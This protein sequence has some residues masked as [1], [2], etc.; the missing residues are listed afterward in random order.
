[1][2]QSPK[3]P[4]VKSSPQD[5]RSRFLASVKDEYREI[6]FSGDVFYLK[7]LTWGELG[8]LEASC[9]KDKDLEFSARMTCK[10]LFE[11][12]GDEYKRVFEDSDLDRLLKA[13]LST[14]LGKIVF[15]V[16]QIIKVQFYDLFSQANLDAKKNSS[17]DKASST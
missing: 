14:D 2:S 4:Q 12:K 7:T 16:D 17:D 15:R 9:S 5:T 3:S 8:V 11:R 1:M 6:R 10:Y 13:N